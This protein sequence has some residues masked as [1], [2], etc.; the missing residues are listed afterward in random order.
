[1][2]ATLTLL[3]L[4]FVISWAGVGV[5]RRWT[6]R[7]NLL[8]IPNDRS[9]HSEPTP[10]GGGLVIVAVSLLGYAAI[11]VFFDAPFSVGY[12]VGAIVVA[13]VS[14]LDD[15]YSLP[16]WMRL[17]AHIAATFILVIDAGFWQTL[18]V[19]L[20]SLDIQLGP[21]LGLA[22]TVA[23]VVWLVNAYNF[24][25]GI[26]GIAALQAVIASVAWAGILYKFDLQ[27]GFLFASVLACSSA[28]FLIHNWQP[29]RIF[30][31]DVGSAFIGFTLAAMPIVA[32]KGTMDELPILP[33]VAVLA[34]W[35]FVFDTVFTLVKRT[36]QRERVW[37]AHRKHL[38]QRLVIAGWQ[39]STVSLI[40][41]SAA[42][43][44]SLTVCLSIIIGGNYG[45]L[46]VLSLVF[47]TAMI[48]FLALQK[49]VDANE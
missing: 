6:L 4:A 30:M 29:A 15:L 25:D 44:L 47:L 12:F 41:G 1:M 34:V 22:L 11:A 36:L 40:Y 38:Y 3:S 26:D 14:W 21:V 24:M 23:W 32:R 18:F 35:F 7:R 39:H 33:V 42:A 27:G 13:S 43:I 48:V 20:I 9:S 16:F 5:F 46:T 37:Q 19:P 8:D 28:G 49:G 10:R 17:I 2:I 45:A 31:G